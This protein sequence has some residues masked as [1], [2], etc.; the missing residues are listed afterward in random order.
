M[1]RRIGNQVSP[2][3]PRRRNKREGELKSA[4]RA[5][6]FLH[7][8]PRQQKPRCIGLTEIRGPYYTPMGQRYLQ[9]LLETMG[10]YVDSLKF[11]G[12]SFSLMRK[13][14]VR[15]L[16]EIAHRFKVEVSTGG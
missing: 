7:T 9:D 5:F 1:E 2:S 4:D 12:G 10:P 8:N 6:A 15:E 16:I 11:A 3:R 13:M 14:R